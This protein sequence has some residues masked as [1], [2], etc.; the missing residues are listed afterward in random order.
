MPSVSSPFAAPEPE[1]KVSAQAQTI[2]VEVGEEIHAQR[3]KG[4]KNT[5]IVAFLVLVVGGGLGF[6]LGSTF[7]ANKAGRAAA[8]NAQ[9]LLDDV[10]AA[11]TSAADISDVIR[12]AE[13]QLTT[14]EFPKEL[15]KQLRDTSIDFGPE[16]YGERKPGGLPRDVLGGMITYAN[17]VDK[18][19]KQKR[20]IA[21][22]LDDSQETVEAFFESKEKKT[23]DFAV[24]FVQ[25]KSA[26]DEKKKWMYGTLGAISEPFEY[27][28]QDKWPEKFKMKIGRDEKEV[29]LFKPES[30]MTGGEKP[31]AVLLDPETTISFSR[32]GQVWLILRSQ[33]HKL[34]ELIEGKE[35][36]DP[37]QVM[38]GI[39]K[40][41]KQLVAGLK[42]V[43]EAGGR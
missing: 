41:G 5:F 29:L 6:L 23:V 21:K 24:T 30:K 42:K 15:A 38:N 40:D 1:K 18:F 8:K 31:S 27:D 34:Y 28:K 25:A 32:G 22:L 35:S 16:K 19:Q 7:Q 20:V 2:K 33:V 11:Q 17:G 3:K 10:V 4:R 43:V 26:E 14:D 39:D 9:G 37:N 12:K 13:E 36:Q